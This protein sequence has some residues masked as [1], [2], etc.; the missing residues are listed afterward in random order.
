MAA[1]SFTFLIVLVRSDYI[2]INFIVLSKY[3][4][5]AVLV[6]PNVEQWHC[7]SSLYLLLIEILKCSLS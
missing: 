7:A 3:N 2:Q 1:A 5:D 6:Q 4:Y